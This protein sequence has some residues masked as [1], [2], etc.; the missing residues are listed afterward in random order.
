[1][2]SSSA[3]SCGRALLETSLSPPMC[4]AHR[5]IVPSELGLQMHCCFHRACL[6]VVGNDCLA[7]RCGPPK[8]LPKT[9]VA[10]AR[11]VHIVVCRC[12]SPT[13]SGGG[14]PRHRRPPAARRQRPKRRSSCWVGCVAAAAV[15]WWLRRPRPAP[16]QPPPRCMACSRHG[17]WPRACWNRHQPRRQQMCRGCSWRWPRQP[18][19]TCCVRRSGRGLARCA[20]W[21]G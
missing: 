13:C 11:L 12:G 14:Q 7:C 20:L 19:C 2:I 3:A 16:L 21:L 5:L 4:A 17:R 6:H 9:T 1:M 18:L 15:A 8:S 10:T